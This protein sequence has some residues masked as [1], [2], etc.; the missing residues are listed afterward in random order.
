[1]PIIAQAQTPASKG[2]RAGI[3][4][5]MATQQS[6]WRD[7][8]S[9]A[10][11][12][13]RHRGAPRGM[14]AALPLQCSICIFSGHAALALGIDCVTVRQS[15]SRRTKDVGPRLRKETLKIPAVSANEQEEID[16]WRGFCAEPAGREVQELC[17]RGSGRAVHGNV[18]A[19]NSI[20][21]A[22]T[23]LSIAGAPARG[24]QWRL[25]A[26]SSRSEM[27]RQEPST[28]RNRMEMQI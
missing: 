27:A 26:R 6:C 19:R 12:R 4:P 25:E 9:T 18:A 16:H 14:A 8:L 10:K 28:D 21:C 3:I 2:R 15:D 20:S 7:H 22:G 13:V 17:R 1:M 11:G 23:A 24:A 5:V